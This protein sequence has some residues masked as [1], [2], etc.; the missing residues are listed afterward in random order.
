[1][2]TGGGVTGLVCKG[3]KGAITTG[4]G[5]QILNV[6]AVSVLKNNITG[7][8]NGVYVKSDQ[9]GGVSNV[10]IEHN[11]LNGFNNYGVKMDSGS[12]MNFVRFNYVV[13]YTG[14]GI[15]LNG[16][17]NTVLNNHIEFGFL[18]GFGTAD[19]AAIFCASPYSFVVANDIMV[20]CPSFG[21]YLAGSHSS[22]SGNE[23]TNVN[24]SA[25]ANG[26]GIWVAGALVDVSIA[27][28][29][30]NDNDGKMVYG[31]RDTT[32]IAGGVSL[33]LNSIT[34][35]NTAPIFSANN[36]FAASL[37][38]GKVGINGIVAPTASA[39]IAAST[40]A[41]AS[42]RVNSGTAPTSPNDGDIWYDGTN[43]KM[44]VGGTTKTFT[45]T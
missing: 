17:G 12:E 23:M 31:I 37:L 9:P 32:S 36:A 30:I 11:I 26:S 33:G 27:G 1:M 40:T 45:L 8:S 3:T 34:G 25:V 38:S 16:I 14:Y 21:I 43:I 35:A 4:D 44:R 22:I 39:H 29:L 42:L 5:I 15:Y 7:F 28:N 19:G 20:G 2:W 41:A 24:I 13:N 6:Q 18:A 10:C